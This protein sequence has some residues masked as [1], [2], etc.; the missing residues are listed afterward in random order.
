MDDGPA[1]WEDSV[2]LC[3]A[4]AADGTTAIVATPHVLRDPWV[5]GDPAA[6]D[7]AVMKLNGLLQGEPAILPGCEY[8]FSSD[9][10]QLVEQGARGPL[11]G[12]NRTRYLLLEF[13]SAGIP[14]V[15]DAVFH[16][17]SLLGVTPAIA[18]PE[19]NRYF[20]AEPERLQDL[21]LRGAVV[22]IT[23]GSL[24]G[25]FGVG[26]LAA[27][28]EFFRRGLVHL[29]ASDAHSL[30]RR[31]PRLGA[32]R[33]WVKRT[34]GVPAELGLFEANPEALLRSD[35]LPWKGSQFSAASAGD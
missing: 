25:D 9:V 31:P 2:A 30:D 34:W 18:H 17:I 4:A 3:R 14:A 21:V 24:L 10:V 20:A 1:D 23:A 33:R 32:A 16:E 8:F 5:N 26:P 12:L 19:R 27:C 13:A 15:T 29:V 22:Q 35:P 6:R 7:K 28:Q 11:I